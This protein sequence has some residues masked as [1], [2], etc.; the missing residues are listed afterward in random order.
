MVQEK[1]VARRGDV[2]QSEDATRDDRGNQVGFGSG[3]RRKEDAPEGELLE[4]SGSKRDVDQALIRECRAGE[5]RRPLVRDSGAPP[6]PPESYEEGTGKQSAKR[7]PND[8]VY[9]FDSSHDLL[10]GKFQRTERDQGEEGGR[11]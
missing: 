11:E 5:M 6:R 4:Q 8:C 10:E 1:R 7:H 2:P 3:P 9:Q